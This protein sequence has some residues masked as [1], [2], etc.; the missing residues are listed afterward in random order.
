M[1]MLFRR[2]FNALGSASEIQFWCDGPEVGEEIV[3]EALAEIDR[4]ERKFSRFRAKSVVSEINRSAGRSRVTVDT[5]T[6]ALLNFADACFETSD[7]LFDVTA[8]VLRRV[9]K[10][11]SAIVPRRTE[12]QEVL[13][14]VGWNKVGWDGWEIF[15]PVAGMEIDLGGFGKEYAVDRIAEKL[16]D[17]GVKSGLVNL[18]G[19]VRTLGRQPSGASWWV[20]IQHPRK[21]EQL[22]GCV[23]I[24][25]LSVATSGDYERGFVSDGVRYH[26]ILSPQT[27]Y[28]VASFQ[29]VSVLAEKCAL[30]GAISTM[31]MLMGVEKGESFLRKSL[32]PSIVIRPEGERLVL[33]FPRSLSANSALGGVHA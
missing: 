22:A 8:G 25:N 12:I 21:R 26:H 29:A 5:E 32:M 16:T 9:W 1:E 27:G 23:T 6:A 24:D 3:S 7:G 15:L 28:P 30:A 17:L 11:D 14:L 20:G 13:P 18:G 33:N 4:I 10:I 2:Q 19:D 31:A